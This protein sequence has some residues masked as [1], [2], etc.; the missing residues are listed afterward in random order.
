MFSETLRFTSAHVHFL[1]C[2]KKWACAEV[3][4]KVSPYPIWLKLVFKSILSSSIAIHVHDHREHFLDSLA[5]PI[6]LIGQLVPLEL[7][8]SMQRRIKCPQLVTAVDLVL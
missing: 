8:T 5:T 6:Y 7:S 2:F 3:K 1:K 4:H